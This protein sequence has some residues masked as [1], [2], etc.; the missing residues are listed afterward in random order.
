MAEARTDTRVVTLN[1]W[2]PASPWHRATGPNLLTI[3]DG[4]R[5]APGVL[6]MDNQTSPRAS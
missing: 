1:G 6:A 3:S 2:T 5:P 4:L